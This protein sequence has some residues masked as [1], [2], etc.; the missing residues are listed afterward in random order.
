MLPCMHAKDKYTHAWKNIIITYAYLNTNNNKKYDDDNIL[1]LC[2]KYQ[3]RYFLETKKGKYNKKTELVYFHFSK[4]DEVFFSTESLV[5]KCYWRRMLI[6]LIIN[7]CTIGLEYYI[8]MH[9]YFRSSPQ[10]SVSTTASF[11]YHRAKD[12][13]EMASQ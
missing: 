13:Y 2:R 3:H 4:T 6:S 9:S 5:K 8:D 11:V 10:H 7:T 1:P 12:S